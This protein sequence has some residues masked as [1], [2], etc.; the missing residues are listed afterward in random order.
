MMLG[1][2]SVYSCST[3][4]KLATKSSTEAKIVGV[5]DVLPHQLWAN[6]FLEAQ[7]YAIDS[8]AMYQDY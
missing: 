1:H 8:S 5:A 3:K 4:Q 2:R 6:R 7:G